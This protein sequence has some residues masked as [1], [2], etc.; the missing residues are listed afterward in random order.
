MVT[1]K[2]GLEVNQGHRNW[3]HSKAWVWLPIRLPNNYRRI[4]IAISEIIQ[5][6]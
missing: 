1:L 4:F 2:C 3:Y 6:Q 5:R